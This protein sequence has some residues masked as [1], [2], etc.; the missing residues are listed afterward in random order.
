MFFRF[1]IAFFIGEI[2]YFI[3]FKKEFNNSHSDIQLAAIPGACLSL[4]LIFQTHG[5][6]YTTAVNSSFITSTY[7]ILIPLIA[8][9]FFKD[10]LKY[11]HLFFGFLAFI[12]MALL[13][14]I[15]ELNSLKLNKGDFYSFIC[16]LLA[17]F[18]ILFVGRISS[19]IKSSFRF[20]TYQIF[21][22][23]ITILPFLIYELIYTE[24]KL[25]PV[26]IHMRSI[27]SIVAL[28]FLVS[29]LAFYLLVRAQ[30]VLNNSITSLLCLLEA[31]FAFLFAFIYLNERLSI[32][33]AIGVGI[34]LLSSALS[35]Y[36]DRPK[37]TPKDTI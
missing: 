1:L 21:W 18:H 37:D 12:G 9:L 11:Q 6:H 16:A 35:V 34:I 20:N 23:L 10:K 33:Q 32:I 13:L 29:L 27:F 31:P 14:N 15:T 36:L 7:V 19:K 8:A 22:S 17:S 25:I 24:Q 3:F 30:K 26:V 4:S 5:L 2:S 28:V